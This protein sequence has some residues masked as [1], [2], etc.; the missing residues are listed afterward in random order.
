MIEAQRLAEAFTGASGEYTEEGLAAFKVFAACFKALP[1]PVS[2]SSAARQA[3]GM[4]RSSLKNRGFSSPPPALD[5]ACRFLCLLIKRGLFQYS[6][7]IIGEIEGVLD[8]KKGVLPVVLETVFPSDEAFKTALIEK[9]KQKTGA[10]EIRVDSRIV[11]GL[12]GGC[13][14]RIGSDSLDASLGTQLR[15]MAEQ[16]AAGTFQGGRGW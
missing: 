6:G 4:I 16:L 14:L 10:R 2:G 13:R 3:A 15:K 5:Y 11:P 7:K 1:G 12:L 9:L 8:R